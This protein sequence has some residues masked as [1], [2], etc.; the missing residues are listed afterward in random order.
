MVKKIL[1]A[2]ALLTLLIAAPAKSYGGRKAAN[3]ALAKTE[4]RAR[5]VLEEFSQYESVVSQDDIIETAESIEYLLNRLESNRY[6]RKRP[7]GNA[8]E[9]A[10]FTGMLWYAK[11]T[12]SKCFDSVVGFLKDGYLEEN[13]EEDLSSTVEFLLSNESTIVNVTKYSALAF[14]AFTSAIHAGHLAKSLVQQGSGYVLSADE[15]NSLNARL[16]PHVVT[17]EKQLEKIE[18]KEL[19]TS[20]EKGRPDAVP[21]FMG[22]S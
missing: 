18:E 17:L 1:S 12:I 21:C 3:A 8:T 9:N 16:L 10:V 4:L 14:L 20:E 6:W 11:G 13:S 22:K 15:A 19:E 7:I 5:Q 2:T